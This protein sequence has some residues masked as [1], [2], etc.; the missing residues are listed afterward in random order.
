MDLLQVK[1][2]KAGRSA[3]RGIL[4]MPATVQKVQPFNAQDMAV[5]RQIVD[6][7]DVLTDFYKRC[8]NCGLDVSALQQ[9]VDALRKFAE[10]IVRQFGEN[11]S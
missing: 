8:T 10:S 4:T 3:E 7:A 5:A 6:S 2:A 11:S 1:P 9:Q